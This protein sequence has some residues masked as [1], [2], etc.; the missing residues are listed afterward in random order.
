MLDATGKIGA[1]LLRGNI[2]QFGDFAQCTG[3]STS[4]KG[5]SGKATRLYGKY[6]LAQIEMR[7]TQT[8]LKEALHLLHGRGLWHAHLKNVSGSSCCFPCSI[9]VF[10]SLSLS[11]WAAQ[12]LCATL[13]HR[14]LGHLLAARL[15]RSCGA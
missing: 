15:L 14:Q 10:L 9:I 1:G 5:T 12:A 2:N 3:V 8:D 7:A 11:I 6:C 13:Q 4:I